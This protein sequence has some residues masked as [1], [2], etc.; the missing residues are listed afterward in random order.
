[1]ILG[2]FSHDPSSGLAGVLVALVGVEFLQYLSIRTG[3]LVRT[4]FTDSAQLGIVKNHEFS[5]SFGHAT[6]S[7]SLDR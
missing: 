5:V 1:M 4:S 6:V 2:G 3:E 7:H